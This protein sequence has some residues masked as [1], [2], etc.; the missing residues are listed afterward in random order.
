MAARRRLSSKV[1][2]Q[3]VEDPRLTKGVGKWLTVP[4]RTLL[5]GEGHDVLEAGE[6]GEGDAL[7]GSDGEVAEL[8]GVGG[9]DEEGHAS[10]GITSRRVESMVSL[11]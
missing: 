11:C 5:C 4:S 6:G 2:F 10:I 7:V 8:A 1:V 3:P 9:G